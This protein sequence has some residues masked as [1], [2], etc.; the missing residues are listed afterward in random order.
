MLEFNSTLV[1]TLINFLVLLLL[2]RHFLLK[3]VMNIM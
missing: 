2:L 1:W 3:P